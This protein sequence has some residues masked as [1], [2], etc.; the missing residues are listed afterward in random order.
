MHPI[1]SEC[2]VC[3]GELFVS[4]LH[5]RECDTTIEG[6]FITGPFASLTPEQVEFV[7]IFIRNEGKLIHMESELQL[8]YPTIRNRLHEVIRALGYEPGK[9]D[10]RLSEKERRA[11]LE[12]LDKGRITSEE[13]ME[14]LRDS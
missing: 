1:P 14:M 12:D 10:G 13:A 6:R 11:I 8:S 5:C 2:P 3:G 4:K 7:E 9:G